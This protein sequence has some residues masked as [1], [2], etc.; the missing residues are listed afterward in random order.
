MPQQ[1][2]QQGMRAMEG[3]SHTE[4]ATH[5][6]TRPSLLLGDISV[7]SVGKSLLCLVLLWEEGHLPTLL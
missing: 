4:K 5:A 7:M 1:I 2:R 3:A 6:Y